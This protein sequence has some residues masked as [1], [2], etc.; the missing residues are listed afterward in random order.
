DSDRGSP[1]WDAL[2]LNGPAQRVDDGTADGQAQACAAAV[3]GASGIDPVKPLENVRQ[4]RRLD[5]NP[6]IRDTDLPSSAI[7]SA[8]HG[9]SA[10]RRGVLDR[11]IEK[12]VEDAA[13]LAAV[14]D[15]AARIAIGQH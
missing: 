13:E 2:K 1:T 3:A 10:G 6:G 14:G 12:I 15:Q 7:D 11:I 4:V 8:R 9:D 5:A